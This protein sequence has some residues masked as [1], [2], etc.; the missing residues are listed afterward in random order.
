MLVQLITVEY[1]LSLAYSC[2]PAAATGDGATA[3]VVATAAADMATTTAARR[4]RCREGR[5]GVT[6]DQRMTR[7]SS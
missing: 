2:T 5:E 3:V 7:S 4:A 1:S 6:N